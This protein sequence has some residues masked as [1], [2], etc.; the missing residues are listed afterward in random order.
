MKYFLDGV[1]EKEIEKTLHL[2]DGVTSNP[3]LLKEE[4]MSTFDFLD[5]MKAY[6][7][8]KFVQVSNFEEVEEIEHKYRND[9][10]NIIFKVT[11]HP[12]FYNLME[13]IKY[14]RLKIAATTIYDII[15]INQAIEMNLDYTMVYKAK[16][17]YSNLFEDAYK[18]KQITKSNIK[19]V[20]ASFRTKDHVKEAILEGMDYST[21]TVNVLQNS[22]NNEQLN[23]DIIQL[24]E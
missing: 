17:E 9:L 15:Q 13:R 10:E 16:N 2:I 3:I 19:L 22:F 7:M 24:Y 4:K 1:K 12:K 5:L 18:L 14:K 23:V 6:D 8:K 20:G 21:I 11:M